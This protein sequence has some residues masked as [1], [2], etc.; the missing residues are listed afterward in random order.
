MIASVI[1]D[2]VISFDFYQT[3]G[4]HAGAVV[5]VG[6]VISLLALGTAAAVASGSQSRNRPHPRRR[7][8]WSRQQDRQRKTAPWPGSWTT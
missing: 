6:N 8:A 3:G 7:Q 4:A 1:A 2:I 5:A